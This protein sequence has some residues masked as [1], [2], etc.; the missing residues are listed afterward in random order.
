MDIV[1]LLGIFFSTLFFGPVAGT[2]H[3]VVSGFSNAEVIV[4]LCTINVLIVLV[5]FGV[6][7]SLANR[8]SA[9]FRRQKKAR[10]WSIPFLCFVAF[11]FGSHWAV[12]G[13]HILN[14]QK[15]RAFVSIT[16]GA[17]IGGLLWTLASLGV[18]HFVPSPWWLY[19]LAIVGTAILVERK[20]AK[21]LD[22]TKMVLRSFLGH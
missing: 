16:I 14:T 22:K 11:A 8:L 20:I 5:W 18:I 4:A 12:I 3:A 15:L 6:I 7:G 13:A 10:G 9:F 1:T 2:A 19:A 21:N 17:V